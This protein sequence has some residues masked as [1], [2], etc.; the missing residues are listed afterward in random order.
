MGVDFA[1]GPNTTVTN[2]QIFKL[3]PGFAYR[4]SNNLSLGAALHINYQSLALYYA[5]MGGLFLPQNQVYGFGLGLGATYNL[6][7]NWR[8]AGAYTTEQQMDEF[9]WNTAAGKFTMDLDGPAQTAL[10]AA[11]SSGDLLVEFDLKHIAFG[12]VMDSVI[13]NTPGGP[14]PMPFGWED[15]LVYAL[16][17]QYQLNETVAV[18]GGVNYGKSPIGPEDVIS[19]VGSPAI[20]EW[21]VAMGLTHKLTKHVSASYS[22]THAFENEITSTD[23]ST[24]I[25]LSQNLLHFQLSYSN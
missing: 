19:N 1:A 16:G 14:Q 12:D 24:T 2:L 20:T 5:G 17:V 3:A 23:G 18:R 4:A 8:V 13:L 7:K 6:N 15:Q 21:H 9:R 25:S 11:Y 10:G 22:Y